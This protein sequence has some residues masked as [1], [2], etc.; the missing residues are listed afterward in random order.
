MTTRPPAAPVGRA[1]PPPMSLDEL[2]AA[3]EVR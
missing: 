3:A 1:T 2:R